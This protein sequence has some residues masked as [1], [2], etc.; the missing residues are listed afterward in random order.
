MSCGERRRGRATRTVD[1][2]AR[3]R[4]RGIG[5][6]AGRRVAGAA[7][8]VAAA[9]VGGGGGGGF[10]GAAAAAA[11]VAAAG[12]G[13]GGAAAAAARISASVIAP[14]DENCSTTPTPNSVFF[15][16]TRFSFL[17]FLYWILPFLIYNFG[18]VSFTLYLSFLYQKNLYLPSFVFVSFL[19]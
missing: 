12:G 7:A 9:G 19:V 5:A 18:R 2:L 16:A 8:G 15:P 13:G 1:R 6:V 10:G 3:S 17:P 11:G 4:V 14:S